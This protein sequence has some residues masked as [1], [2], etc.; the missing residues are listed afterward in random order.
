M[1]PET[2]INWLTIYLEKQQEDAQFEVDD[3]PK[4]HN[5]GIYIYIYV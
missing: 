4:W 3:H 5:Y 2:D 1:K